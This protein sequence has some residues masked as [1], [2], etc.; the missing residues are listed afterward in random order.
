MND[1]PALSSS[2]TPLP[3][4]DSR[5]NLRRWLLG[6]AGLLAV[7]AAVAVA[8]VMRSG[9]RQER[10]ADDDDPFPLPELSASPFLNTRPDAR[11]VGSEACRSCHEEAHASFRSTG[12]GRSMA[13]VDAARAPPD[14][15]F[16]H[17]PSKRRYQVRRKDGQ[18]WHRELLLTGQEE[19]LLAEY[20]VK[21]VVGSGDH[22]RTYGVEVD[23][24]LVESPVTWYTAR[25]AWALSPGYEEGGEL[26]FLRGID[27]ACLACH[28]GKAEAV[29]RSWHRIHVWEAAISCERCHGPGSLHVARHKPAGRRKPEPVDYT[30][31]N[32]AHL[33]RDLAEAICQQCHL[34][35]TAVVPARG[36]KLADF[37]P[38]LPLE[39]FQ[40]AYVFD[41]ADNAMTVVGHVEQMH[42]SRCYQAS[43]SFSCLTCHNPH[44]EPRGADRDRSYNSVCTSCHKPQ[45]CTVSK[46]RLKKESPTNNCVHCHMPRSPTEVPHLAFTHH[47]VGIHDRGH[48]GGGS[49]ARPGGAELRPFFDLSRLGD[50]DRKRSLGLGYVLA[51]EQEKDAWR[52]ARYQEQA[53]ALLSEVAGGGLRDPVLDASLAVLRC[54]M[55]LDDWVAD[56]RRALAQPDLGSLDRA[57][58]LFL[59]AGADAQEGRPAEAARALRELTRARRHPIDWLLLA[60]CEEELGNQA[61]AEKA[62]TTAVGINPRLWTVHKRLAES[63]RRQGD[64]KRAAWHQQRAVP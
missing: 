36:R 8:L 56:A 14:A 5:R 60:Q 19:L 28:A 11:Y 35:S 62:L 34:R 3:G 12:M 4:P 42:H 10:L 39:D 45:Q 46:A 64:A 57:N 22:A 16:D 38:G 1:P 21:W 48:A 33:S 31:V 9:P 54:S 15:V 37:R 49:A 51:A 63:Y 41:T 40:H 27:A 59:V 25:K 30:I 29:D 17:P 50:V 55:R 18:M 6:G 58:V 26:G 61:A 47:R 13:A 43:K 7:A 2:D 24:F 32:P 44:D 53:L 23:G 20:P 52:K